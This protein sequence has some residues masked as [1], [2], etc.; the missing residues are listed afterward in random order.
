MRNVRSGQTSAYL[1]VYLTLIMTVVL[2]LYLALVE[3]ARQSAFFMEAEC[4]TDVGLNSVMAE[5][6]R[7]LL[8]QYNLF[9]V[10]SSYGTAMPS[11]DVTEGRLNAYI[12]R[13]LSKDDVFLD[14]LLYRDFVGGSVAGV[15]LSKVRYLTDDNGA[16]F[17]RRAVEAVKDDLNLDLLEDLQEWM[18]VIESEGLTER[19]V[20]AEKRKLDKEL[21]S[22]DGK[23]VY[24]TE[25]EWITVDVTNPT[26]ALEKIRRNGILNKIVSNPAG[27][28]KKSI[29][30]INLF[31]SRSKS[32]R[33]NQG[34]MPLEEARETDVV[35][36][37]FLFQEYLMR[38]MG[39]Y[40]AEA[41]ESALSYQIE[42]L[43]AGQSNDTNNLRM[44]TEAIL[45]IREVA[46][47]IY[48]SSDQECC[49]VADIAAT[50]LTYLMCI[51]EAKDIVKWIL[52][53]GWAYA[54]S[55]YDMQ[56]LMA[57][58]RVPLLKNKQTWHYDLEAALCLSASVSDNVGSNIQGLSYADYLRVLM[59]MQKQNK[60][61]MRAINMVEADI[62]MTEG[63]ANFRLDGCMDGIEAE[64]Q[65]SN[66]FGYE[67]R[68]T[69]KKGYHTQ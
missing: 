47:T 64:V 61:I 32:G 57:G 29:S 66:A 58:E 37:K 69:R 10:D 56:C 50:I 62:R 17:R 12:G 28:S 49:M 24:I 3:S 67:C 55:I 5:Y 54:E 39:H 43:I 41:G 48:I 8:A 38:Y 11:S 13:N 15:E 26:A 21:D 45:A 30:T 53:F 40:G 4:V 44:V 19:D 68:I 52:L 2:S 25:T 59:W 9:G 14:W 46:N 7:E 51:P 63:N 23:K 42:Y 36:E 31:E 20:A 35:L 27:L 65:F 6:H 18:E 16:V 1:T 34:N 22:Y 33:I 60:L